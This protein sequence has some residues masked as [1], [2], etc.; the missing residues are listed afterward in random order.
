MSDSPPSAAASIRGILGAALVRL[1]IPL[2]V[3][4][5]ALAKYT[6]ADPGRLPTWIQHVV[7]ENTRDVMAA[8]DTLTVI[9]RAI[10]CVEFVAVGVMLLIARFARLA[11]I[12]IMSV[13]C[14]V[15]LAEIVHH[16]S[17]RGV[18]YWAAAFG[19]DCG[20]FGGRFPIPPG[21]M[22]LIDA[23]LALGATLLRPG[24]TRR[25]EGARGPVEQASGRLGGT[26][27]WA[28]VACVV[29][30]AIG[31]ALGT[32][33]IPPSDERHVPWH[34]QQPHFWKGHPIDETP[35]ARALNID[36]AL[37]NGGKQVWILYRQTC[38]DCH[39]LFDEKYS[40]EITDRVVVAIKIP[41][42][43]DAIVVSQDLLHKPLICP[44][45]QWVELPDDRRW[46]YI[47]PLEIYINEEGVVEDVRSRT[48][49]ASGRISPP[50][51][52]RSGR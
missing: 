50:G 42:E 1:V 38:P 28:V 35:L 27:K 29:W 44:S 41:L 11:A 4:L 21:V 13:F 3:L 18:T 36:H 19:G 24:R 31:L 33:P 45:C 14:F 23:A 43:K 17:V 34:E 15:L 40:K 6:A 10:L 37:Y 22:L 51:M 47:S 30:A 48:L 26:P 9:L 52:D 32:N 39:A 49:D 46:D 7:S 16:A 20:C 12:V 2:W 5:G 25:A 8:E